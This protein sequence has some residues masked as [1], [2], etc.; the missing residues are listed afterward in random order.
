MSSQ[1]GGGPALP[2]TAATAASDQGEAGPSQ[3]QAVPVGE[4]KRAG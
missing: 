2:A 1:T 4:R 3:D